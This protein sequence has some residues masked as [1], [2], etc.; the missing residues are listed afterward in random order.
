MEV[1]HE[2]HEIYSQVDFIRSD[3]RR[4]GLVPT[5]G[6]LHD[7]HISLVR[8][9]KEDCDVAV[10]TIFVNPTQ[11]APHE[12]LAKYPRTL[13]SDLEKLRHVG[14]DLVFVPASDRIYRP[15][16]STYV[17]APKVASRW[18]G[19]IRPGHFR[20]V[21][22]VVLKLFQLI[23]AHVAFFGQK[24]HQQLAV[25]R[26]MA[27]DLNVPI[28][29]EACETVREPD[30]LAMSSRN[31]YLSEEHRKRATGIWRAL[32]EARDAVSHGGLEVS[33][34]ESEMHRILRE[35]PFDSIDY[36]VVVDVDS[37]EP[38]DQIQDRAVA[39]I[40]AR[41]GGTR[42]IDNLVLQ[43]NESSR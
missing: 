37:L 43:A 16:H 29:I 22:T 19:E 42:L 20:G 39:L 18:E 12:D 31:R 21:S 10:T 32:C 25:I 33:K 41:L 40:A 23:P 24:D 5:M 38:I 9:A 17:D 8:R 7:G 35:A 30:G 34:I 26:A 15:G 27:E 28:R 4:V 14:C 36:A 3:Q 2:P 11:F 13:E 6:A 1:I